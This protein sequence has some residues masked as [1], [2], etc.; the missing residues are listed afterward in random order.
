MSRRQAN[1]A[2]SKVLKEKYRA[3]SRSYLNEIWLED[4]RKDL[5]FCRL[6]I[7]ETIDLLKTLTDDAKDHE[8]IEFDDKVGDTIERLR[9][10][11]QDFPNEAEF[12]N[13]EGQFWSRLG[14]SD[15]ASRAFEKAITVRPRNS[16]AF[17]RLSRIQKVSGSYLQAEGTLT[18]ALEQF[19]KDKYVHLQM[20][21]LKFDMEPENAQATEYHL[22]SSFGPGDHNF[23][24]RFLLAG[25]L[26][27]AGRASE[28]K[29]HFDEIDAKA[30]DSFRKH[31][32]TSDDVITSKLG[33]YIG[34]VE[35]I[36][37]RFFFIRFGGYPARILAHM[38]SLVDVSFDE[39]QAGDSI[40]FKIRFNRRGPVAVATWS[41]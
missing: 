36:K 41:P 32:P 1:N 19:P 5:S 13:A 11:Q 40:M 8:L 9:R 22:K 10:A 31:A 18:K 15:R 30:P 38:S 34:T 20:A 27:W 4:S 29:K 28:S 3:Q 14:E 39:L 24:A 17:A 21:M 35:A 12:P 2:T 23:E 26:F 16:G 6:L 7:D 25:F 33:E 37:E